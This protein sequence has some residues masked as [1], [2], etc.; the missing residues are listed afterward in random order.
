[1]EESDSDRPSN[2]GTVSGTA[3][4]KSIGKATSKEQVLRDHKLRILQTQPAAMHDDAS[5]SDLEV[6][7]PTKLEQQRKSAEQKKMPHGQRMFLANARASTKKF[8]LNHQ[9][10]KEELEAAQEYIMKTGIHDPKVF[11]SLMRQVAEKDSMGHVKRKEEMWKRLGGTLNEHR[12]NASMSDAMQDQIQKGLEAWAEQAEMKGTETGSLG[13]NDEEENSDRMP[14]ASPSSSSIY[15]DDDYEK[16]EMG[17]TNDD[18]VEDQRPQETNSDE[19]QS[20]DE[21]SLMSAIQVKLKT[22]HRARIVDSEQSDFEGY[23]AENSSTRKPKAEYY[24]VSSSDDKTEDENDKENDTR[25]MFDRSEDKEN[26]AV[27]RHEPLSSRS[28]FDEREYGPSP[29]SSHVL[30]RGLEQEDRN[31]S[32]IMT[33]SCEKRQPFRVISDASP[34]FL[35]RQPSTLTQVFAAQLKHSSQIRVPVEDNGE[36]DVFGSTP[37]VPAAS[38]N[39]APVFGEENIE[40]GKKP[41]PP[42]FLQFSQDGSGSMSLDAPAFLQPGFSDLFESGTQENNT[43]NYYRALVIVCCLL[44]VLSFIRMVLGYKVYESKSHWV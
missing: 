39:F 44:I 9:A 19:D 16:M 37:S 38:L 11:Q 21:K 12:A 36:E 20:D 13:E 4:G 40:E 1:M 26:K 7:P 34:S 22:R 15:K 5:D 24:L 43:V 23:D 29:S 6:V 32:Q 30:S 41:A 8:V 2:L 35:E 27:T 3:G 33:S 31:S 14:E 10:T 42:G 28:I 18:L 17:E 25:L